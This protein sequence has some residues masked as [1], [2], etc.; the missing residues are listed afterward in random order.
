MSSDGNEKV[1]MHFVNFEERL[2]ALR[3]TPKHISI[4][5]PRYFKEEERTKILRRNARVE[6]LMTSKGREEDESK[7]VNVLF[8]PSLF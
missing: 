2:R 3:F 7:V 1:K 6:E 8:I 4:P 5:I